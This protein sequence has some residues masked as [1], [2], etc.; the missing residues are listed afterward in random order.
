MAELPFN[1]DTLSVNVATTK[2]PLDSPSKIKELYP[3]SNSLLSS[4]I[5]VVIHIFLLIPFFMQEIRVYS[6]NKATSKTNN[7]TNGPSS[8]GSIEI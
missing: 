7:T 2:I 6:S 3:N 1:K 5:I 8:G 4:M